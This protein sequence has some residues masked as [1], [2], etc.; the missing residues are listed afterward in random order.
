MYNI[1][2]RSSKNDVK[3]YIL[4]VFFFTSVTVHE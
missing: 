1:P 2:H 4:F 3:F